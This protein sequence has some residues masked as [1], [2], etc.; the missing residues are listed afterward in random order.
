MCATHVEI[1]T[2]HA[3]ASSHPLF[4]LLPPLEVS[5]SRGGVEF[6]FKLFLMATEVNK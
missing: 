6:V 1:I 2:P 5:R 4:A 3:Q